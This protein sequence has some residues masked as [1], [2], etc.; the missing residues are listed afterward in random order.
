MRYVSQRVDHHYSI[1]E[2]G[3]MKTKII[4]LALMLGL[5]TIVGACQNEATTEPGGTVVTPAG[6]P[7]DTGVPATTPGATETTPGAPATTP[8]A[9]PTT[10][11]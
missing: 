2:R 1:G 4:S 5:A 7:V 8:A 11:P 6:E 9:T 3:V 10:S